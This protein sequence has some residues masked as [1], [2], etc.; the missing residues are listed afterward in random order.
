MDSTNT[1]I[2][3]VI[4]LCCGIPFFLLYISKKKKTQQKT[5]LFKAIAEENNLMINSFE[6][7]NHLAFGIDTS[8]K[9]VLITN[10]SSY[11]VI[12]LNQYESAYLDVHKTKVNKSTELITDVFIGLKTPNKG[13]TFY[14]IFNEDTNRII[15]GEVEVGQRWINTI[16]QFTKK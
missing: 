5:K 9:T 11:N 4:T 13:N 10:D 7:F 3:V 8:K 6:V 12:D 15:D 14:N 2:G 16:N 1:I